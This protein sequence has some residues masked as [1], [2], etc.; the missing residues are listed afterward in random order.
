MARVVGH[1]VLDLAGQSPVF[2]R[3]AKNRP[4]SDNRLILKCFGPQWPGREE[5]RREEQNMRSWT[6]EEEGQGET[7]LGA[8]M[9]VN[10][11]IKPKISIVLCK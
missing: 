3:K 10:K 11:Q 4:D 8:N 9:E 7:E 6:Q 5:P 1:P 2:Y